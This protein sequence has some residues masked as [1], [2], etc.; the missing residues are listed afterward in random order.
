[1]FDTRSTV[2]RIYK[3]LLSSAYSAIANV[4]VIETNLRTNGDEAEDSA[5]VV[6]AFHTLIATKIT[7]FRR[8]NDCILSSA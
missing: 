3:N 7:F 5:A 2:E 8:V 1:M 6:S 4:T